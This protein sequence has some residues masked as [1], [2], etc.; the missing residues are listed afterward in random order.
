M[1]R[2]GN[3]GLPFARAS[4][5]AGSGG[6]ETSPPGAP[7]QMTLNATPASRTDILLSWVRPADYGSDITGY[8]LQVANGR[9]GPWLNVNPQPG[10]DYLA[11]DY[12][13][14]D[15][16]TRRYFRIRAANE[17]GS[18]LWSNVAEATTLAAGVPGQPQYVGA[19][20]F[21]DNAVSVYWQQPAVD[22]GSAVTQ[23]EVQWSA[24]GST[25][26]SRVGSTADTSLN[27]TGLTAG[28]EYWYQVR[29]RNSAG[30]GAWAQTYI[31]AVPTG[32]ELPEAPYPRPER[33][34]STAMD[35]F[36]DPP[37]EDGGGDI[38]GYQIEWSA[39]GVEGTFRSLASPGAS[40]RLYTHTG[41]T[42]DTQYHYRMRARNSSGYGEWSETV[43]DSTER[44]VVPDAPTLTATANGSSE[45]N[46]SWTRP[47]GN[48][49]PITEYDLEYYDDEYQG[50]FW[51]IR[52]GLSWE[53]THYTDRELDPGTERQYRIRAYND[54]GAGQW[55]AVRTART[56]SSELAAPLGL[57]AAAAE[58]PH[59]ERRIVL[60][61]DASEGASSYRIERSRYEDGPWERLSNGQRSTTYTDSRDLYAGMTR[62]Y[63]VAATGSGGTGVW[64]E[65]IPGTTAVGEDGTAEPPDAPTLLRFTSVG[66]DS[67]GLAWDRPD[68][69]GGAPI[70]GYEY[71]ESYG[72]ESFT[73]TGTTGTVS[74]LRDEFTFYSF[75]VRAVNAVGEGEWSESIYTSLWPERSEQVRVSTTNITVNEGGTATFTVS[76]NQQPPLPVGLNLNLRGSEADDLLG[77]AY[78]YLDKVLI[79]SG[80]SHPDGEDWSDRAHNW[81]RG[82]PVSIT[83]PDDDVVNGDRVVAID[84]SLGLLSAG[85]LGIF[86]DEWN[87]RWSIDP[88][89]PCPGDPD[90][91]C[92]TEWDEAFWREFTGPSVKI[93]VR[94]NDD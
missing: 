82:V 92:P 70:T 43:W 63:R 24:D 67:V 69:D 42:A 6:Q 22:N 10:P 45:I 55:S 8:T 66:Q 48:G 47:D 65:V 31:P 30:W 41:L 72:Q 7:E 81:S 5:V 90:S 51:L 21:G 93:T 52:G 35:I 86:S 78:Q 60:T 68:N 39:T 12:G 64:S 36:W 62:Y 91:T 56:D 44:N 32:V 85:L 74:G 20:P 58:E 49:A 46:L 89:R 19:G 59:S 11:W 4:A 53:T 23:Y 16:N 37:W 84:V 27:H 2:D 75:E 15:A 33:N 88:E 83:I 18:G 17:F 77:E 87:A 61:W 38:T 57:S 80:W 73:T 71:R 26:W 94:D 54:N 28:Q 50:W 3:P 1:D 13:G 25:G 76:L 40:A 9:N 79:P 29:A 34:G 14:L